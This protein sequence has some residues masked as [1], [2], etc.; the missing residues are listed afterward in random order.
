MP[1]VR[2]GHHFRA[3]TLPSEPR[4]EGDAS[5]PRRHGG[6]KRVTSSGAEIPAPMPGHDAP[7]FP[8]RSSIQL[9]PDRRRSRS[10]TAVRMAAHLQ[11]SAS[12]TTRRHAFSI[13]TERFRV[14][15]GGGGGLETSASGR[16]SG[17][18][19]TRAPRRDRTELVLLAW[20]HRPEHGAARS[21]RLLRLTSVATSGATLWMT[22]EE[23][24]FVAET[25]SVGQ[26]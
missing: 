11:S 25:C 20:V 19:L 15:S 14:I 5:R 10:P 21:P 1:A 2:R 18:T 12:R 16:R 22:S 17:L 24:I 6:G 3:T 7:S 8:R 9:L 13:C 26:S 4:C 23:G